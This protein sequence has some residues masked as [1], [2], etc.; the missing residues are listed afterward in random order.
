VTIKLPEIPIEEGDTMANLFLPRGRQQ[1][2]KLE[3]YLLCK[4][5]LCMGAEVS[6]ELDLS[7]VL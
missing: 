6:M 1:L 3:G 4:P 7:Y 2:P 5:P